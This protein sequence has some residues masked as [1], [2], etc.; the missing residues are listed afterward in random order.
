MIAG[1]EG[2]DGAE[3]LSSGP[4]RIYVGYPPGGGV[5]IVAR[6]LGAPLSA[7]LGQPVVVKRT[8]ALATIAANGVAKATPDGQTLLMAASGEIAVIA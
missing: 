1:T 8:G 7:A 2:S 5:D 3:R 6:L 4:I